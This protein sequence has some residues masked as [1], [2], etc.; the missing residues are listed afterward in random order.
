MLLLRRRSWSVRLIVAVVLIGGLVPTTAKA[1]GEPAE[2]FL[3]RLRAARYFDFAITYLDRLDKYPG[4]APDLM[5]SIPLEKAQTYIDA[6]VAALSGSDR[7]AYLDQAETSLSTF[8]KVANHPRASEA[9]LQLGKLQLFRG[10]QALLGEADAEKRQQAREHYLNSSKTFDAIIDD[11]KKKLAEM[12]GQ[13]IDAEKE[14]EKA[15]LRDT[16]RYEYVQAQV[17]AGET[18]VLAAKTF[19]DPPKQA[20]E[21]LEDALKRFTDIADKYANYPQGA[22]ATLFLGQIQELLGDKAKAI[23]HYKDMV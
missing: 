8:L 19:E 21:I 1:D 2:D 5:S 22:Q 13:K 3:K 9:Q 11:L 20:K 18:R 17:S 16:Y 15:D 6:A 7:E 4:V 23:Q 12:Q 14:P 10:N